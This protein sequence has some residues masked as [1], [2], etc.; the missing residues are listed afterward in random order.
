VPIVTAVFTSL[1]PEIE[2][3]EMTFEL[4]AFAARI[5]D[6]TFVKGIL[7]SYDEYII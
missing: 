7:Y 6:V 1:F 3:S 4:T 5:P 2:K